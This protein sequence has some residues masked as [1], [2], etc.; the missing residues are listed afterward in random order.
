MIENYASVTRWNED[1]ANASNWFHID[2]SEP[3]HFAR[4]GLAQEYYE[5]GLNYLVTTF[6][7]DKSWKEKQE[8]YSALTLCDKYLLHNVIPSSNGYAVF[9][10][11]GWGA[12]TALQAGLYGEPAVKEYVSFFGGPHNPNDSFNT[13]NIIDAQKGL[14][15]N[16]IFGTA[17][18]IEFFLKRTQN[19]DVSATTLV[20]H[21][22]DIRNRAAYGGAGFA[23]LEIFSYQAT[24]VAT[25]DLTVVLSAGAVSLTTT[26]ASLTEL[27]DG[28]WHH[29]AVIIEAIGAKTYIRIYVDGVMKKIDEHASVFASAEKDLVGFIGASQARAGVFAAG[30]CKLNGSIDEFRFWKGIRTEEE[31]KLYSRTCVFG[32]TNTSDENIELGVYFKFNEGITTFSEIDAYVEDFSGRG[33]Q[34]TWVGYTTGSRVLGSAIVDGGFGGY[35]EKDVCVHVENPGYAAILAEYSKRGEIHDSQNGHNVFRQLPRWVVSQDR[36]AGGKDLRYLAHVIGSFFDTLFILGYNGLYGQGQDY[37][38]SGGVKPEYNFSFLSSLGI[39]LSD[40]LDNV[41]WSEFALGANSKTS[42]EESVEVV[43]RIILGNLANELDVLMKEKGTK[44]AI[45]S[46]LRNFG[47][48]ENAVQPVMFIQN[49]PLQFDDKYRV[50]PTRKKV[51][52]FSTE[53]NTGAVLTHSFDTSESPFIS[54]ITATPE[55]YNMTFQGRFLV[56]ETMF[57]TNL[58]FS[59][60]GV[61]GTVLSGHDYVWANPNTDA[62]VVYVERPSLESK[63]GRFVLELRHTSGVVTTTTAWFNDVFA[64]SVWAVDVAFVNNNSLNAGFLTGGGPPLPVT[65]DYSV[66]FS[67]AENRLASVRHNFSIGISVNASLV[68]DFFTADKCAFVGAHREDFVGDIEDVAED[69]AC[70][71][72][73]SL[74]AWSRILSSEERSYHVLHFPMHG[75]G[76]FEDVD[77]YQDQ[78]FSYAS[79]F[80]D[81]QL[82]QDVVISTVPLLGNITNELTD[83]RVVCP[84]PSTNAV[85]LG[86]LHP[87]RGYL[88]EGTELADCIDVLYLYSKM[89]LPPERFADDEL[90]TLG[91]NYEREF[92]RK[93][94]IYP[95]RVFAAEKNMNFMLDKLIFDL[96]GG[97]KYVYDLF[98]DGYQKFEIEYYRLKPATL[99]FFAEMGNSYLD[100][101]AFFEYFRWIDGS[102][103]NI[104][105]FFVTTQFSKTKSKRVLRNTVASH[106]LER[107]KYWWKRVETENPVNNFEAT[108]LGA[109]FNDYNWETG[110]Y[111]AGDVLFD[112]E[113]FWKERAARSMTEISSADPAVDASRESIRIVAVEGETPTYLLSA[114]KRPYIL[115]A[116]GNFI[117]GGNSAEI[118][119]CSLLNTQ[120]SGSSSYSTV[121]P[122][123]LDPAAQALRSSVALP[124]RMVGNFTHNYQI[125]TSGG[126]FANNLG[127]RSNQWEFLPQIPDNTKPRVFL[128]SDYGFFTA[129]SSCVT[130]ESYGFPRE[131]DRKKTDSIFV[132]IF[133]APG[134]RTTADGF[135]DRESLEFCSYNTVN[136]RNFV[137]RKALDDEWSL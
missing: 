81:W 93:N 72:F 83:A 7:H 4:Y 120:I 47:P 109:E 104:L 49:A 57:K 112:Q 46:I 113:L 28:A 44:R 14:T 35:E 79:R 31:L 110:H 8:W 3:S 15:S 18:T 17:N 85:M 96:F 68:P 30:A 106:A 48:A 117:A 52:D 101:D 41:S 102:V 136:Y 66:V 12:Q 69:Y 99:H 105:E 58:K 23:G 43:K 33:T 137:V 75:S 16:L 59:V 80:L 67:G 71:K 56:P 32:G 100:F 125:V 77:R 63:S 122:I 62:F 131:I 64:N 22:C 40:L 2:F 107:E 135:R 78:D 134:D 5:G 95:R 9:S 130:A 119:P 34:G 19:A 88:F 123:D 54:G 92:F 26:A 82:E 127:F 121:P 91:D 87:F 36:T 116:E 97:V 10:S 70:C 50:D 65:P 118:I 1:S 38:F 94:N 73:D 37:S 128:E 76:L 98:S 86:E 6:P 21:I 133:S 132:M 124:K 29:Y 20:E 55:L 84:T 27:G 45:D 42:F 24:D 90:V 126:R 115:R 61:H 111:K 53:N 89:L 103:G 25:P 74:V 13:S 39:R 108:A 114:R 11:G 51:V 129:V 60:F